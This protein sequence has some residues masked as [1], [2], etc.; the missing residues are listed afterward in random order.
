M[1][2][3]PLDEASIEVVTYPKGK[4]LFRQ[5]DK[6]G[7]A[8][9]VNSGAVGI[10]REAGDRKIPLATVRKGELFGEMAVLDGSA[11]MATAFTLEESTLMMISVEVMMDKMRKSDP[12]IKALVHML[13][14]NLRGVHD[15][16]TPK[17][18]S[19]LD[20][21]NSL[22]KQSEMVARFMQANVAADMKDDL[23]AKLKS[24]DAI[25]KELRRIAMTYRGE[26]R[27]DNAIPSEAD[28]PP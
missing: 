7:A 14:N 20:S 10:F 5:G 22:Q 9:I 21:V 6:G 2:L 28:L 18:R 26:D 25:V 4:V 19:L 3:S 11:R 17:S 15:S 24:L 16:Y 13:M 1:T 8:Y 12:F 27:R 23:E